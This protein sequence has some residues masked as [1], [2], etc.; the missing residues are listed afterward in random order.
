MHVRDTDG[1]TERR[2]LYICKLACSTVGKTDT[3]IKS[4]VGTKMKEN[5]V[6]YE[7]LKLQIAKLPLYELINDIMVR[8]PWNNLWCTNYSSVQTNTRF[9]VVYFSSNTC[10]CSCN[11]SIT[12]REK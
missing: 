6:V 5:P 3:L 1:R 10:I 9:T 4:H 2:Y 8:P 11:L 7:L 12:N